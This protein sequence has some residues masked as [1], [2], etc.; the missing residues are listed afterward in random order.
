[1]SEFDRTKHYEGYE[2][3][4]LE[5]SVSER[6]DRLTTFEVTFPRFVLAE[7]NTHKVFSR[8]SASSRAI[9][10]EKQLAKV[11]DHSFIPVWWG[12][13]QAGMQASSEIGDSDRQLASE[14]WCELRDR[15]ALGV[16]ALI[17]GIDK[18][19][20]DSLKE[21]FIELGKIYNDQEFPN[22]S[23]PLHKQVANRLLEP[24]MWHTVI[25]TATDWDNF[26]ALRANPEA[27]PE[28]QVAA[29]QMLDAYSNSRPVPVQERDWHTPLIKE[30]ERNLPPEERLRISIGRCARSSYLTHHGVRDHA[31]DLKLYERLITSGHMSPTEHAAT[32]FTEKDWVL[33]DE[34]KHL[35]RNRQDISEWQKT[36]LYAQ[37]ERSGNFKGWHQYRKSLPYEAN[38]G[39]RPDSTS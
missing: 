38:F 23:D 27:Q 33:I 31:E 14:I 34:L 37:V 6:N 12:A 26:Y 3:V 2:A 18:L 30:E 9:P 22:L 24:F 8:N 13:A 35:V 4:V 28:I 10:V 21:R 16:V 5:D 36:N 20:D 39:S 29:Q 32:P 15:A 7:F 17:G 1:M 19:E 25:V 11:L